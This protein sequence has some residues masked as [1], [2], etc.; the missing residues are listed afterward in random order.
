MSR[1]PAF[2]TRRRS[3]PVTNGVS[4]VPPS[5]PG[6]STTRPLQIS[7]TGSR[8][9]SP[10]ISHPPINTAPLSPS[11]PRR[12]ELRSRAEY[13][14]TERASISSLDLYRRDSAST[15][16]SDNHSTPYR[17]PPKSAN[18]MSTTVDSRS[19]PQGLNGDRT[20][21]PSFAFR[22]AGSSKGRNPDEV[23]DYNYQR[24]RE[25]EIDAEKARQQRIRDNG[26]GLLKKGNVRRG[27][28]DGMSIIY[29]SGTQLSE[30]ILI[31]VNSRS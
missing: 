24:D 10:V 8:P 23:D 29:S 3:P 28:I 17:V 1:T 22:S 2:P 13:S 4:Y 26:L 6:T 27:E 19:N 21:S 30:W 18:N 9:T 14:E 5:A 31:Y 20:I 15:S 16:R 25:L 12:S 11:R 7:R